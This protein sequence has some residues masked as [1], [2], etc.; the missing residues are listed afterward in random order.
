MKPIEVLVVD[1]NIS[2][3]FL[4]RVA[5]SEEPYPV[6]I[7]VAPSSNR[8]CQ[9][10]ARNR[11]PP[12]LVIFDL[13]FTKPSDLSLLESIDP[14]VPVVV[15]TSAFSTTDRRFALDLGVVEYV[16]KPTH[17]SEFIEAVLRVVRQW[18]PV[19]VPQTI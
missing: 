2:D 5:L 13:N 9:M 12:D 15:F 1:H 17:P 18:T 4:I 10:L 3:I 6:N 16:E 11:F 14:Y 19:S 7:R 8:A